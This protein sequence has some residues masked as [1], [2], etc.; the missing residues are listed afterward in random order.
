MLATKIENE[1]DHRGRAASGLYQGSMLPINK[2]ETERFKG[3]MKS[4]TNGI[5][6]VN[7]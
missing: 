6:F 4:I 1:D 5:I 2:T 3:V 7:I